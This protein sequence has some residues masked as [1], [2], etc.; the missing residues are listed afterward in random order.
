MGTQ[1]VR[2][3]APDS[4]N[5][6]SIERGENPERQKSLRIALEELTPEQRL[7]CIWKKAGFSNAE[8]ARYLGCS[9]VAVARLFRRAYSAL[10]LAVQALDDPRSP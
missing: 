1:D 4:G 3:K 9:S 6:R 8:I 7:V 5:D 2:S 10:Q